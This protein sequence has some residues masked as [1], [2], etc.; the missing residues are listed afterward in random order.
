MSGFLVVCPTPPGRFD[1]VADY[2]AW[3]AA[4]LSA[5]APACL[6]GLAAAGAPAAGDVPEVRR[7]EIAGWRELWRRRRDQPFAAGTPLVQYVPQLYVRRLDS[8]WLLLWL[9]WVRAGGRRTLVTVHEYAVPAAASARR[10]AARALLPFVAALVGAVASHVV[11]TIGLTDRRLRRLLF[12]KRRRIALVPVGTNVPPRAAGA[13]RRAADA[14]G[15]ITCTLFGQPAA[16]SAGAVAAVGEW[17][18]G[19]RRVRL[20]WVGRSRDE[21]VEFCARRCGLPPGAVEVIDHQPA[22][23]VS[24]LLASSDL[25]LAPLADGASTRRTTVVAALAHGLPVVGTRGASTD[26]VLSESEACAL[27]PVGAPVELVARLRALAADAGGRA[28]MS[29]AAR[30]LYEAHFTWDTIA[31]AYQRHLAA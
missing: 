10:L 31:G 2:A 12:W 30:A 8:L 4:S 19:E 17:A 24:E 27:V 9:A 11:T 14:A 15:P 26:P 21:I 29:R 16:M 7:V 18:L 23:A 3:L 13:S 5:S 22:A 1:G 20:R 28:R 6:V 25:F